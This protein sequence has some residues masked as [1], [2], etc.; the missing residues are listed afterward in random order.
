LL[1]VLLL[2]NS[3][4]VFLRYRLRKKYTN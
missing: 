4:A 1:A 2:M 3:V